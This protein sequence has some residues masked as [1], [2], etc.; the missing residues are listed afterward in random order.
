MLTLGI[1]LSGCSS[2][3]PLSPLARMEARVHDLVREGKHDQAT[4]LAAELVEA[5][6][7]RNGERDDRTRTARR[8]LALRLEATGKPDEA[9]AVLRRVELERSPAGS[10][11]SDERFAVVR[12]IV[13]QGKIESRRGNVEAAAEHYK[14]ANRVYDEFDIHPHLVLRR[15]GSDHLLHLYDQYGMGEEAQKYIAESYIHTPPSRLDKEHYDYAKAATAYHRFGAYA[16]AL[17][18]AEFADAHWQQ[19]QADREAEG[20]S[21]HN[22]F[23]VGIGQGWDRFFHIAPMASEVRIASLER[24]GAFEE[25]EKL[26]SRD[27]AYWAQ[28]DRTEEFLTAQ[29]ESTVERKLALGFYT[30][31]YSSR[32][33]YFLKKGRFVEA[34]ADYSKALGVIESR[35]LPVEGDMSARRRTVYYLSVL[36]AIGQLR[37]D[38]GEYALARDAFEKFRVIASE[39]LEPYHREWLDA[40]VFLADLYE[41]EGRDEE[42][43]ALWRELL[44]ATQ[45]I[46]GTNHPDTA[47]TAWRLAKVEA[48]QG[49]PRLAQGHQELADRIWAKSDA[50]RTRAR[51]EASALARQ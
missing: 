46:R 33:D 28:A 7:R 40:E 31:G 38:R 44:D 13:L 41:R 15:P 16:E 45:E 8:I 34:L 27:L 11:D 23:A 39:W 5:R 32:A 10:K 19:R 48:R 4:K 49:Y 26:R 1:L 14:R 2:I 35:W 20:V 12:A 43:L 17:A 37:A 18:W 22:G 47:W 6:I 42:A 51:E 24:L 29:L 21:V 3:F 9:I 36:Q 25:A 50:A 30:V